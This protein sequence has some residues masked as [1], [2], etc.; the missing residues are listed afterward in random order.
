MKTSFDLAILTAPRSPAF[1]HKTMDSLIQADEK[2]ADFLPIHLFVDADNSA[3]VQKYDHITRRITLNEA[4]HTIRQQ[5]D[6]I[7]HAV[8]YNYWRCLHHFQDSFQN[9]L[10]CED[11]IS[12]AP[13]WIQHL[14]PIIE[15]IYS[16]IGELFLLTLYS[17]YDWPAILG[18]EHTL[19]YIVM[20][21]M[22][23]Y[24]TQ[25]VLF[26]PKARVI[27]EDYLWKEG[28]E[29][30]NAPAD[31]R[32]RDCCIEK[33]IPLLSLVHSLVQHE[34]YVTSGCTGEAGTR[35]FAHRSPT[36]L[37]SKE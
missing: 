4:E 23:F 15:Q 1:I 22:G 3:F 18:P 2:I 11:D 24:G 19:P 20:K 25:A 10:V 7:R 27:V 6:D 13:R 5:W 12:F 30:L 31:L 36:F 17:P 34:G 16:E 28:I 37:G 9:L 32:V 26:S 14:L 21:K 33:G 29:K 35:G 8:L